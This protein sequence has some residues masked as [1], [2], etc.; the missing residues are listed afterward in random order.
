[1][2]LLATREELQAGLRELEGAPAY[3][4]DTEFESSKRGKR[5]SLI[6]ISRGDE[7]YLVD[8]LRL[9]SLQELGAVLCNPHCQWILHAGL[10]DVELLLEVFQP[11]SAPALFDTQVVW[12]L[13]GPEASVSLAF[14]QFRVLGIRSSKGYQADDWLRRPLPP[15][16]LEYAASDI[17]HLPALERHLRKRASFPDPRHRAW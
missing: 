7:V 12:G 10:Q 3:Y 8:A 17:A 11:L 5:L 2:R 15:A 6:Q 1:M 16:Q 9:E 14:L 4:V 13:L